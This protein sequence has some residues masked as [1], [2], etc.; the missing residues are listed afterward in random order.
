MAYRHVALGNGQQA[1]QTRFGSQQVVKAGVKRLLRHPKADVKQVAFSVKQETEISLPGQFLAVAGQSLQSHCSLIVARGASSIRQCVR[2]GI[3]RGRMQCIQ[4][5]AKTPQQRCRR[6]GLSQRR[7]L[8][9]QQHRQ[10]RLGR[11]DPL[12]ERARAAL[13]VRHRVDHR[14]QVQQRRLGW[15]NASQLSG[16]SPTRVQ[17][18]A[19]RADGVPGGLVVIR[20]RR[21]LTAGLGHGQQVAAQVA[22]VH[23]GHVH[24][25]HGQARL[26]VVPV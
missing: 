21:Q 13:T 10:F 11:T 17:P 18:G 8:K 12:R 1:R 26:R 5:I 15:Q 6:D 23:G 4:V 16:G 14:Q 20:G 25:Q 22:T 3:L 9:W 19:R 24:G 2:R 7:G